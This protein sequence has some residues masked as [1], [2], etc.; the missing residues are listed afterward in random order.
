MHKKSASLKHLWR[1]DVEQRCFDAIKAALVNFTVLAFPDFGK[2]FLLLT[3]ASQNQLGAALVQLDAEG[4]P[5]PIAFASTSLDDPQKRYGISDKEGLAVV[6]ST[7]LWRHYLHGSKTLVVTDH[8]ALTSLT[9]KRDFTNS[10]LARYAMDLSEFDI[11][12]CHRPGKYHFL[13][14]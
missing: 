4:T 1:E 3:D 6:W 7:R 13:P 8:S 5:H 9:S 14:D 12:I 10:R 2:P 11:E